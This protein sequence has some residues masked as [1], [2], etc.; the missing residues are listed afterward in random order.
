MF[1]HLSCSKHFRKAGAGAT[2]G[3]DAGV[4]VL[5][6]T[7]VLWVQRHGLPAELFLPG[8]P[9]SP[10]LPS[11]AMNESALT[12]MGTAL[13]VMNC[14]PDQKWVS[15][16]TALGEMG[17]DEIQSWGVTHPNSDSKAE[18]RAELEQSTFFPHFF[19]Q[20]QTDSIATELCI[21]MYNYLLISRPAHHAKKANRNVEQRHFSCPCL[22]DQRRND[23]SYNLLG[24]STS[25]T[26]Y[27]LAE[28]EVWL[29]SKLHLVLRRKRKRS[30]H[31]SLILERGTLMAVAITA[32]RV[33]CW[34]HMLDRWL[35]SELWRCWEQP[36][37]PHTSAQ[38]LTEG[39]DKA[40]AKYRATG[41]EI[42]LGLI[43]L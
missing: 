33:T 28:V 1:F 26:F 35:R 25:S 16:S 12:Q 27:L 10:L 15:G 19:V 9:I 20:L 38:Y 14:T 18:T 22:S 23:R 36:S 3:H 40:K 11:K 4:W 8:P 30:D 2:W 32:S 41:V 7:E 5:C 6:S 37:L 42:G 13:S 43:V 17:G 31:A 34:A 24:T 21:L 29:I 39:W